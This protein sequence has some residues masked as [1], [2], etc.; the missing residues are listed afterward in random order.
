MLGGAESDSVQG[1]PNS[2][3]ELLDLLPPTEQ[4]RPGFGRCAIRKKAGRHAARGLLGAGA[5]AG[6]PLALGDGVAG[7]ADAAVGQ[8]DAALGQ[9][10]TRKFG[11]MC[12]RSHE[13]ISKHLAKKQIRAQGLWMKRN[14][15]SRTHDHSMVE[16][17]DKRIRR[18]CTVAVSAAGPDLECPICRRLCEA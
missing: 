7:Q 14:G 12:R 17:I 18:S 16:A 8:G 3:F 1:P 11:K 10:P 9:E 6:A 4:R 13:K 5:D 15:G 2:A